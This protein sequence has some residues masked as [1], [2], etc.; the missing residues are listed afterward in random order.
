MAINDVIQD[1]LRVL[2]VDDER[3]FVT[4]LVKRLAKRGLFCQGA[5]TGSEAIGIVQRQ[6]L[7]VVLL[8]MKLP[9]LD[10]HEVLR[11]VKRLK[12][13]VQVVILTGHISARDGMQGIDNGA[14]D[15]LMKP[16]EFESLLDSLRRAGRS[17]GIAE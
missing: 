7:D 12:P 9:D 5:F 11:E 14:H 17:K 1:S 8:D 15:Y 3:E 6:D 4:T 16:V 2:V 10:G 13:E